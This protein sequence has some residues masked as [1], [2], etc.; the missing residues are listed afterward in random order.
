[1]KK[2]LTYP[3]ILSSIICLIFCSNRYTSSINVE[4]ENKPERVFY[5]D[6]IYPPQALKQGI[7]GRVI[8]KIHIDLRGNVVAVEIVESPDPLFDQAFR[9]AAMR[10]K[11]SPSSLQQMYTIITVVH[12]FTIRQSES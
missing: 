12:H 5:K 4:T 9:E 3:I 1:M 2:I 11:Y 6:P 8:A 10:W 7:K